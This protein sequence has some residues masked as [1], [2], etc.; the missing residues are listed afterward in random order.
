MKT[1]ENEN[2]IFAFTGG[3]ILTMD[4]ERGQVEALVIKGNQIADVGRRRLEV[5]S[6]C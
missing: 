3:Q 1:S 6:K 4:H 2:L 5:I